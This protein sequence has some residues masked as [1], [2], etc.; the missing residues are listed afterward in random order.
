MKNTK[1]KNKVIEIIAPIVA[2]TTTLANTFVPVI[3]TTQLTATVVYADSSSSSDSIYY[4]TYIIIG[5]QTQEPHVTQSYSV[6]ISGGSTTYNIFLPNQQVQ[7]FK[8]YINEEHQW[9][10]QSQHL[11]NLG[12][13]AVGA[14]NELYELY[15]EEK[16]LINQFA[17]LLTPKNLTSLALGA[18]LYTV[19]TYAPVLKEAMVGADNMAKQMVMYTSQALNEVQNAINNSIPAAERQAVMSCV[20]YTLSLSHQISGLQQQ[21]I[22]NYLSRSGQGA[23][24][25]LINSCLRGESIVQ[26]FHNDLT[27]INNYLRKFNPRTWMA[28]DIQQVGLQEG[29]NHNLSTTD[30]ISNTNSN[31]MS[32]FNPQ[33]VAKVMLISAQPAVHYNPSASAIVPQFVYVT[34]PDGSKLLISPANFDEDI[35]A[36][37]GE[38]MFYTMASITSAANFDTYYNQYIVPVNDALNLSGNEYYNYWYVFYNMIHTYFYAYQH[39]TLPPPHDDIMVT[40]QDLNNMLVQIR[41]T[42]SAITKLY[43]ARFEKETLQYLYQDAVQNEEKYNAEHGTNTKPPAPEPANSEGGSGGSSGGSGGSGGSGNDSGGSGSSGQ[44]IADTITL[45]Y[46]QAKQTIQTVQYG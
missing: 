5:R 13:M 24:N 43:T 4:G 33:T 40:Q 18:T 25:S 38:Q 46:R 15:L 7:T 28:D 8:N 1:F 34:L 14:G 6:S 16:N 41:K 39:G 35:K 44:I 12:N 23:L 45:P 2:T 21:D 42:A 9:Y 29:P 3:T 36:I 11:I 20:T 31:L 27:A 10:L 32:L 37:V 17:R 19:G 26:A 22:V 30:T